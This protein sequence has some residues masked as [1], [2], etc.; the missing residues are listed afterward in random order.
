MIEQASPGTELLL[1]DIV[2]LGPHNT[3]RQLGALKL[4]IR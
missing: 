1:E 4:T 2:A 3:L